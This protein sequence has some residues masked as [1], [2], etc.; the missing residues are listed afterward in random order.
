MMARTGHKLR[1]ECRTNVPCEFEWYHENRLV[2]E[3]VQVKIQKFKKKFWR[4]F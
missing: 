3:N 1:L 4:Q 2:K